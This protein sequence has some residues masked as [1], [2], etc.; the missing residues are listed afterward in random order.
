MVDK[1][2]DECRRVVAVAAVGSWSNGYVTGDHAR[3]AQSIVTGL[4]RDW[5]PRQYPVIEHA[6]HVER[7]GVMATVTG[8]SDVAGIGVR[9]RRRIFP[10]NRDAIGHHA[11]AVMAAA[12]STRTRHDDLR[13][14]VVRKRRRECRCGMTRIAFHRNARM[15][16]RT[17]IARGADRD[18]AVV[19]G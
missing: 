12:L 13:I 5:V 8:L 17:G 3:G 9:V 18:S 4:T 19:A 16:R 11:Q 14:G 10:W 7:G 6:A 2:A 1:P 15:T